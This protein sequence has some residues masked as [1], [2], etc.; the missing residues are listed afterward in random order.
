MNQNELIRNK[1]QLSRLDSMS[2]QSG[3][4][5]VELMIAG[6]LSLILM[7]GVIQLFLGSNQN[8]TMQ[9]SLAIIQEDGRFALMFFK[10]QIQK[11][12][13]VEDFSLGSIDPIFLDAD[14]TFD[15]DDFDSITIAYKVAVGS[16]KNRDCNGEPTATGAVRNRF[17]VDDSK[18]L[19][20]AGNGGRTAQPLLSNVDQFQVL[21][22]IDTDNLACADGAVN[23]FV[24]ASSLPVG[25][26]ILSVR[27]ALLL[28]SESNVF[29]SAESRTFEVL[30]KTHTPK[31]A[32]RLV[33]RLFQ[34]TVYMPNAVYSSAGS[35]EASIKCM[36]SKVKAS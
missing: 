20:C 32:D 7:A 4:T 1:M 14:S 23:R 31:P 19:M 16:E 11:A 15:G 28:K 33:R 22:G 10:D 3:F 17:Y 29:P 6:V 8:Y 34:Q 18:N 30:D 9:N 13:W 25:A 24:N 21:Y 27:V 12:G 36:I 26:T 5:L 35:P 2:N